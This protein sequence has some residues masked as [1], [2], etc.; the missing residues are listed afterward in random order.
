MS[1]NFYEI[2]GV[3]KDATDDELKKAY[4]SL[5]LKYHPDKN[6]SPEAED[7][8]K[9]IAV[10]YEVLTDKEKRKIYNTYGEEALKQ[11]FEIDPNATYAAVFGIGIVTI[12][13]M[14]GALALYA[15]L[16][17]SKQKI[18]TKRN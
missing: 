16:P 3:N 11:E 12:I 7:L 10:A 13:V 9:K 6:K 17:K 1:K 2:L 5:A 8:F 18:K 14:L 4:R 15:I